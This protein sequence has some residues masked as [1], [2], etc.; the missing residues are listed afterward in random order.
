VKKIT[1]L[2][3]ALGILTGAQA[4]EVELQ[5]IVV[6]PYRTAVIAEPSDSS[7]EQITVSEE[8]R[9]GVVFLKDVLNASSSIAEASSGS[10]GGQTSIFLRGHNANHTRFMIDGIKLYD[11]MVTGAYYNF[12]NFNLQGIQKIEISKGPQSSLYGSDAIGGVI[13]LFTRRGKGEPRLTLGQKIGSFQTFE[14]S[15]DFSGEKDDLGYYFGLI[16]KDSGGYSLARESTGNHERDPYHNLNASLRLDYDVSQKT[17]LFLTG[18]YI[19]A[20]YEYD[21]SSWVPP[22]LPTDD[23]DNYAYDEQQLYGV[24]L[25]QEITEQ[26]DYRLLVSAT[27]LSRRGW[28]DAATDNWYNGKTYQLDQ[29]FNYQLLE[30]YK[31]ILGFD[32]LRE[33]GDSY[34]VDSGWVSDF[35]KSIAHNKGY[36]IENILEPGENLLCSFSYRRDDHSSF[37]NQD[38][39]RVAAGYLL[40]PIK[41]NFKASYG[42]GFKA[43]SLY[44]QYAPATAWGPIGNSQLKP[45]ESSTYEVGFD[46]NAIKKCKLSV[47]Y[48]RSGLTNLIDFSNVLGY[49]NINKARI[50]G[51][52]GSLRYYFTEN[53]II[54]LS[55]TWLDTENKS[56]GA[57]LGRRPCNKVVFDIKAKAAQFDISFDI[58]YIG[59]RY[60][61]MAGTELLKPYVLGNLSLNYELR[62]DLSLYGRFQNIFDQEYEEIRGYQTEP[63]AFYAGLRLD[64]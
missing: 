7:T 30:F 47:I 13:N 12:A 46:N 59:H 8:E 54:G 1:A 4:Q 48:F 38:T 37:G 52:E 39:Y 11:P 31:M 2:I 21:G 49:V 28:E 40:D 18:R 56:N 24:T 50:K 29:Q 34:R 5:K 19:Y 57:E 25:D 58:S 16:R 44:Q 9:K 3:L 22:Y 27:S 32:Y 33:K 45:E 10:L 64:L 36:F 51:V 35:P 60:S 55:H 14:E 15:L 23:D 63:F 20:K 42:T 26:L 17:H 62:K 43:P 6:T 53:L 41:T 61:D